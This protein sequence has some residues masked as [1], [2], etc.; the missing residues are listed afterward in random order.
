MSIDE[1]VAGRGRLGFGGGLRPV[2]RVGVRDVLEGG[3]GAHRRGIG[4]VLEIAVRE[5]P[6]THL[7]AERAEAQ[8]HHRREADDDGRGAA[9]VA[10]KTG[11]R[12]AGENLRN[13]ATP[14]LGRWLPAGRR[15]A[16]SRCHG[17]PL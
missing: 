11:E 16:G 5:V 17:T 9:R 14:L 3:D 8:Q 4:G 7:R 1:A 6:V 15:R 12:A 10:G 2:R 13:P